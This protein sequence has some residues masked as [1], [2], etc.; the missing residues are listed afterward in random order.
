MFSADPGGATGTTLLEGFICE[1]R[2]VLADFVA[3]Q[4]IMQDTGSNRYLLA[5]PPF[6]TKLQSA[7]KSELEAKREIGSFRVLRSQIGLKFSGQ[8]LSLVH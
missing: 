7:A 2:I 1:L 5:S 4:F 6:T 8:G 3:V